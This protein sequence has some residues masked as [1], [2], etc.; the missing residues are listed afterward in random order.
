MDHE[1]IT[2]DA[3]IKK[4]EESTGKSW[5]LSKVDDGKN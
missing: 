2:T 5:T 1:V 3:S 4:A